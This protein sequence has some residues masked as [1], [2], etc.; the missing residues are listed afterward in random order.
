MKKNKI[1]EIPPPPTALIKIK[2]NDL[3]MK[4]TAG[5]A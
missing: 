2:R 5:D 1:K 4:D 3:D